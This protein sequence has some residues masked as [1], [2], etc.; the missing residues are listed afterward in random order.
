MILFLNILKYG[1]QIDTQLEL[2][3]LNT[4]SFTRLVSVRDCTVR[5]SIGLF[6]KMFPSRYFRVH[7]L[8]FRVPY[9]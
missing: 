2:L 8:K 1:L 7:S 4:V 5:R 9:I 3:V 6:P